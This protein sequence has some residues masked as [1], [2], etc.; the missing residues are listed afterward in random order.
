ML[1]KDYFS[2]VDY[3]KAVVKHINP[4][5]YRVKSDKMMVCPLHDDINPSMGVILDKDGNEMYHCF[6]CNQWGNIIDLHKKVCR[7]HLGRYLSEE[8]SLKDLCRIFNV[9]YDLVSE[10]SD[11]DSEDNVDIKRELAMRNIESSFDVSDYKRMFTEG[12]IKKK[13]IGYFNTLTMI[14]VNEVK[15]RGEQ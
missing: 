13:K 4:R 15:T 11:T 6:G 2:I 14:M 12:K 10:S 1:Y 3:Y 9:S 7:K 8:E 5:K